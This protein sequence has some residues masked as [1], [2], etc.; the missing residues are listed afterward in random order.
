MTP[1]QTG[2]T[3]ALFGGRRAKPLGDEPF[4]GR[5]VDR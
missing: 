3:L 1:E 5:F 2:A 4:E